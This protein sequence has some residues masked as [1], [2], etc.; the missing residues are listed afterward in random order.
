M[1]IITKRNGIA[2]IAVLSIL[3]V[4]TLLLPLM[5]TMSENAM[6]SAMTGTDE[7]KA[8]YLART[9][10]EFTVGAFQDVYDDAEEDE[11]E[12]Y[13]I[14]DDPADVTEELKETSLYKLDQF[15]KVS[16][17]MTVSVMYMYRNT[18]VEYQSGT[19]VRAQE[20]NESDADYRKYYLA[21]MH[22]QY[23][24]NG[25]IYSTTVPAG[26]TEAQALSSDIPYGTQSTVTYIDKNGETQT[27]VGE[28]MGYAKCNV[29]YNDSTDYFKT[30]YDTAEGVWQTEKITDDDAEQQY[31]NY[32]TKAKQA[33]AANN[34]LNKTEPQIFRVQNKNVEFTSQAVINEKGAIRRCILVLPT[35][36][37]ESN[38]IVP[39]N[40]ESNQIFP[41]TS[42]CSGVTALSMKNNSYFIDDEAVQGQP[43]YGFSC[44]GN[45]VISTKKI[46]YK[47]VADDYLGLAEGETMDYTDYIIAYNEKVDAHNAEVDAHNAEIDAYNAT[48]PETPRTDYRSDYHEHISSNLADFSLGLHPETTTLNPERDPTF[49]CLKTNNMR[50]WASSAQRDNFVAFTA[51]SGIQFDMPVNIIMNPCRTGRIGDGIARNKSLYKV[52][53]LQAP[54]IV[55][56]DTVN[57][58]ISL[59]TK[60][61]LSALLFDYNAYRMSTIILAAPESTPYTMEVTGSDGTLKT[62]KAGK[63][64][65]AEDAYV[66]L[67]P[68]TENGSNYKT[69]SVYYKGKDIIL[70]KFANAGDVFL[71][72]A[73]KETMINGELKKAGFSMTSYFMDVIYSK[74]STDTNNL[75]WWQLWSGIQSLI[76]DA[77][78]SGVREKTYNKED[79]QWIGNMNTGTQSAPNIDDFYVIWES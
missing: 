29:V 5:F 24:Q 60:T 32:L 8:S 34:E 14:P 45:M 43:V 39:A 22:S 27:C 30:W 59:Y 1:N 40:I 46:K 35:K 25:I 76:F 75:N 47:A 79:L 3:L 7:Q 9:M 58:F 23:L 74:D 51:T 26:Y 42:Q 49:N 54:T 19:S 61:S 20:A 36:P 28:Y 12:G 63:V 11:A 17:K 4:L 68:F 18:A 52:L 33:I 66:W 72:N 48:D 2:L 57:S 77:A 10:I 53:Y 37:A 69:Q 44:I 56:N 31:N 65:F 13:E 62:V 15:L 71:F 16:K 73:E 6:E 67:V 50:T 21:E 41:D 70:Y 64:Y 55:F 38:W 78:V